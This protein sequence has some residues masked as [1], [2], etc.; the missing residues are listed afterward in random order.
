MKS[1]N[2]DSG[3]YEMEKARTLDTTAGASGNGGTCVVEGREPVICM[4]GNGLRPSHR[5][6]AVNEGISFTLNT[7]EQNIVA[8]ALDRAAYNQGQ[9]AQFGIGI[10]EEQA[11]T[12]LAKGPGAVCYQDKTGALCA[13]DCHGIQN[14]QAECDKYIVEPNYIVRRLT[15]LECC[16]L[17]GFP[18]YWCSALETPEPTE[19]DIEFWSAVFEEYRRVSGNSSKPKT[20]RQIIKWLQNPRTDSAEYK[21]WGN[22]CALPCC[23]F[24]LRGIAELEAEKCEN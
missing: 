8:Y 5:G 18:D 6:N 7:V 23:V 4:E 13:S 14:Q 19:A 1:G 24:A 3:I 17:Q 15:P 12:V 9:N 16:R 20:G 11:Q 22:G 10:S 2:P 21:M